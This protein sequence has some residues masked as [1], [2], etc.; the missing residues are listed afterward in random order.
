MIPN[1]Q[2]EI[3]IAPKLSLYFSLFNSTHHHLMASPHIARF[4]KL[5]EFQAVEMKP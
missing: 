3:S 1:C 4:A 2:T 5:R